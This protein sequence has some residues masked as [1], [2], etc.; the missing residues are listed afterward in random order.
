M[1]RVVVQNHYLS[2][3]LI[4]H[5]SRDLTV[6]EDRERPKKKAKSD[7]ESNKENPKWKRGHLDNRCVQ[8]NWIVLSLG[9]SGC[10]M[11]LAPFLLVE[12]TAISHVAFAICC[13]RP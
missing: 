1:G 2:D 9:V 6:I 11:F 7:T 4:A 10:M 3:Q 12:P 13:F 5:I 8:H